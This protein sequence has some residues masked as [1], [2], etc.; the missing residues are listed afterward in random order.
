[1]CREKHGIDDLS[2]LIGANVLLADRIVTSYTALDE[3]TRRRVRLMMLSCEC[4]YYVD[5]LRT[6]KVSIS[7]HGTPV[8]VFT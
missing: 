2:N 3:V 5:T 7:L 6:R 1:M 4:V 8:E